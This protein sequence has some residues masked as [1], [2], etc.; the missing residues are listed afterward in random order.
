MPPWVIL[1]LAVIAISFGGPLSRLANAHPLAVAAWRLGLS[2]IAVGGFLVATRGWRQW[3][4]L[5]RPELPAAAAAGLFLALPFCT[6]LPPRGNGSGSSW[7]LA[8]RSSS[9]LPIS[10]RRPA[11]RAGPCSVTCSR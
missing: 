6:K 11:H 3:R 7:Q 1:A 8:A 5:T 2:L 10:G 4:S 9:P